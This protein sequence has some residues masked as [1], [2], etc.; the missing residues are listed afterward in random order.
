MAGIL[1][2]IPLKYVRTQ[3]SKRQEI[4]GSG[5]ISNRSP[6]QIHYLNGN[7]TWI[8]LAS[9][10]SVTSEVL[11]NSDLSTLF[12]GT[13][14]AKNNVLFGGTSI[15]NGS[16][17]VQKEGRDQIYQDSE[18]G[19]VPMAG[20]V[21]ANI[22]ALNRGSLKKANVNLKVHSKEQFET[23]NILYLRLGYTVLL[24]WGNAFYLDE[25]GEI[26]SVLNTVIED[27]FF[28]SSNYL[29]LLTNIESKRSFYCGNYDGILGTV[30]NFDWNF[31]PD[32]SYDIN[33][34]ILSMGDIIESL[35]TNVSIDRK[36]VTFLTD[37]NQSNSYTP[38]AAQTVEGNK[39]SSLLNSM[40]WLWTYLD[41][42][43][44][45]AK[46]EVSI[47]LTDGKKVKVGEF[48][49][50]NVTT[51]TSSTKT[52][53]FR[54]PDVVVNGAMT[55]VEEIKP[56][57][58]T[59]P[60]TDAKNELVKRYNLKTGA[61]FTISD[62]QTY[63]STPTYYLGIA[64]GLNQNYYD[65]TEIPSTATTTTTVTNPISDA[66]PKVA[67][68]ILATSPQYYV[69]F[70]Y[71]L[72]FIRNKI[73]PLID[74]RTDKPPLIDIAYGENSS[75]MY[76]LP[77]TI[78][79]NPM[80]CIVKNGIFDKSN[81]K[82]Q[83]AFDGLESFFDQNNYNKAYPMNIYLNTEFVAQCLSTTTD[84]RGDTNLFSFLVEI[85]NGI[86]RAL[87]G[88]NNLEPIVTEDSNVINII[89]TT[90]IPLE[91]SNNSTFLELFGYF[92][93]DSNFARKIE[94]KTTITPEL[95]SIA[96]V[97]ATA[98]G[99]VKGTE[100][101]SFSKLNA[102]LIDRFNKELIP[103]SPNY[104]ATEPKDNYDKD[105]IG[106]VNLCYGLD[107]DFTQDKI[108][109]FSEDL[110]KKNVSI[111]TEYY[112]YLL[113]TSP[114]SQNGTLGF[115]PFKL[116]FTLDGISGL[117]IYNKLSIDTRF[118]PSNYGSALDFLVTGISHEL[119]GNDWTTEI[120][121]TVIGKT[122]LA[123]I[124][125][126]SNVGELS[127][128]PRIVEVSAPSGGGTNGAPTNVTGVGGT[129]PKA[130]GSFG[131]AGPSGP[132]GPEAATLTEIDQI[133]NNSGTTNDLRKRIIRIA[134][135]YIGQTELPGANPGWYDP[136]FETKMLNLP[137]PW[138]VGGAWCNYFCNLSWQ[139]AY[140]TGN[141]LVPPTTAY[142]S[143]WD[144]KLKKGNK[145]PM[146][147][148]TVDTWTG[149]SNINST[150][151][152]AEAKSG[153]KLPDPGDMVIFTFGHIELVAA[154]KIV[155]GKLVD[156]ST[157]GGNTTDNTADGTTG[158]KDG[159]LTKY[160]PSIVAQGAQYG[161]N[162]IKGFCKV[163]F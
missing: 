117:K 147:P 122:S 50:N 104:T 69:K 135:S 152:L 128:D 77:I 159:G 53:K 36:L 151:T 133:V 115:I 125:K 43:D 12:K 130:Q 114:G 27:S 138:Y 139:E 29:D 40:L 90:P 32:G 9:G 121:T 49:N 38:I 81:G 41:S 42:I 150:I 102:G 51:L 111:V 67:F 134:A 113:A 17:L 110:I 22:K 30:T 91:I 136:R 62:I 2:Q 140:T 57:S 96:T 126:P 163:Q 108:G 95:A 70:G 97:G 155:G 31:N 105:F 162:T 5:T 64:G 13:G 35:K 153:T 112:K 99:Y 131:T 129:G 74:N 120:Q 92:G 68:K 71:L 65:F 59:D 142:K 93:T 63:G 119:K 72:Q 66:P 16:S 15:F 75:M 54:T 103:P 26:D 156:I 33:I 23:I 7:N 80:V 44:T 87:G 94:L 118:L 20:I 143:I 60:L 76:T 100:A 3:I 107:G 83:R 28:N 4:H 85:C 6:Q 141:A 73:V 25:N 79:A 144:T 158:L 154:T 78:S 148:N 157:I 8:K 124:P 137:Q 132:V 84:D 146:T 47:T 18:F 101:I 46:S 55:Y 149:F 10:A 21:S 116:N 98:K 1:G 24:E 127:S 39:A 52:Y 109:N 61:S 106:W 14:L 45:G 48:I 37:V 161:F 86:N 19:P 89:D 123:T 34:T 82:S 58:G 11:T 88:V 160:K 145:F 56:L